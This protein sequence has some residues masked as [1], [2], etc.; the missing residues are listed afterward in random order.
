MWCDMRIPPPPQLRDQVTIR[1]GMKCH[2]MH[3]YCESCMCMHCVKRCCAL[4]LV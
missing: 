1:L 2:C 4:I 3:V